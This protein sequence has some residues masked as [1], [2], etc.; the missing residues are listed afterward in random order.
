MTSTF[1]FATDEDVAPEVEHYNGTL[2][3]SCRKNGLECVAVCQN[4]CGA[5]HEKVL[6]ISLDTAL[7]S[8]TDDDSSN[9]CRPELPV[10]DFHDNFDLLIPWIK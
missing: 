9:G 5:S 6:T 2:Q 1:W 3:C 4:C 10:E 8:D 7:A